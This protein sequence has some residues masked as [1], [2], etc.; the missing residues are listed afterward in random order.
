MTANPL[1][2]LFFGGTFNP[3]HSGHVHII[4]YVIQHMK[5]EHIYVVPAFHPPHKS[6]TDQVDF[7]DRLE[8]TRIIFLQNRNAANV[9]VSDMEKYLPAPSYT[10]RTLRY[11][12][13]IHPRSKVFLLTGMDMYQN[14]NQ[15]KNYNELRTNYNFIV[16]K[17]LNMENPVISEGD[18]MLDNPFWNVS[19]NK[20]RENIAKYY[21]TL[22]NKLK[23][24]LES[25]LT[26]ELLE[27]IIHR[28]LYQ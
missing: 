15:W 24:E 23:H 7:K 9:D 12:K 18:I 14:L 27:Y 16:L 4:S 10:Y 28:K 21:K 19:S 2:I 22:D 5:F 1:P 25:L 17:R 3:P 11:L 26:K 6:Q 20:L 8:M 13:E